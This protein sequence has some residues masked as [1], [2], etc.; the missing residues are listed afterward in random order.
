MSYTTLARA[1][2]SA[3]LSSFF[4]VQVIFY[5]EASLATL[6]DKEKRVIIK[7]ARRVFSLSP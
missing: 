1:F 3:A 7:S 5:I 6:Q 4:S 2:F